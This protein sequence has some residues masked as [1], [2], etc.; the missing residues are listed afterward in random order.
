MHGHLFRSSNRRHKV[1]GARG[2]VVC[3]LLT[4]LALAPA[5]AVAQTATRSD[6]GAAYV[7]PHE[8]IDL[9]DGRRLNLFCMGQGSPAV[10]L[11]S[12]LSDWSVIWALVQPSVARQTRACSYDRAGMGYSD[13]AKEPRTPIAIVEDLH[14]LIHNAR[15][16]TPLVLVGHSLGGFNMKLYAALYPEDVSGLVLV[17]PSEDRGY[18]R[19]RSFLRRR[20]GAAIAAKAELLDLSETT[21]AIEHYDECAAVARGHELDPGSE[22]YKSCTDPVRVPLGPAIAAE[23]ARLQVSSAYQD[24]Q[25]SELANSLYGDARA[26]PAYAMLFH[27]GAFGSKPLIVLTH[28]IYD[29]NDPVE[30][31]SF[32]SWNMLHEQTARLSRRGTNRIVANTHHNIE[33]DDP[34]SIAT[35]IFEVIARTR[36]AELSHRP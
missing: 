19:T 36:S 25:A 7:Q 35:A 12:G 10:V 20:F 9:G 2:F 33:V 4:V 26:D 15:L 22:F 3:L 14:K 27:P 11:D 5:G 16:P 6:P 31:A 29:P 1:P 32:A 34:R 13:P 18:D 30:V 24:T 23:R 21:G 8:R 28:S 17:D